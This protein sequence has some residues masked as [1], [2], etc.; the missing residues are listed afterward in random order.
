VGTSVAK[1]N[2]GRE[3]R[4]AALAPI[5]TTA[6]ATWPVR[7]GAAMATRAQAKR[8]FVEAERA[9]VARKQ[10]RK[11]PVSTRPLTAAQRAAA[12]RAAQAARAAERVIKIRELDPYLKC[13]PDTSVTELYRV[14]EAVNGAKHVHLVFFDRHGW[15]CLHGRSCRAVNDVRRQ[16]RA[17]LVRTH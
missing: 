13:G 14:D 11:T 4:R 1:V 15:Y 6:A 12:V 2:A 5:R 10:E 9:A 16:D 7:R 8:Q 17:H 3:Q